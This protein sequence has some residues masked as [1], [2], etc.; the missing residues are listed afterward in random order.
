MQIQSAPGTLICRGR[1]SSARNL[2]KFVMSE[3]E[4][5]LLRMRLVDSLNYDESGQRCSWLRRRGDRKFKISAHCPFRLSW[6][7]KSALGILHYKM[8]NVIAGWWNELERYVGW[9]KVVNRV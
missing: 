5:S 1:L 9:N 2:M 8:L 6:K 4:Q 3:D 7:L